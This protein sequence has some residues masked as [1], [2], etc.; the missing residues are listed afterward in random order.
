MNFNEKQQKWKLY[1]PYLYDYILDNNLDWPCTTCQWGPVIQQNSQY[2]KQNIFFACRTDGTYIEQE[3]SWQKQPSQLIV[4]QIDIPQHGKCFNQELRNVYLQ[5]NLKKHTNLKIKQ[6]IIHPGDANIMKKCLLNNKIIATKNDSGF[7]FIWDL[8]KHKNQPQF[9]NTK[10][11]NIPE[12]KLIG[13]STKS[14][15]FALSWA[16]NSYR[17]ASGGKDLAILIWDIENYQTRLSNNYLLNKRELNH[18]GNQNEQFKLKNNITL[19][20]HTEMIEDIS[21]SPNKKDVLVSVGDDKKLL[22]WDLRVSHEK[23]Q[24][25]NDLHNDDINCVDWSIPN[26][27]YIATGS[28]DGT[29]CVMDIRNYKKIV[30]IKTNNEQILNEELSQYSVMSIKFAPF[31]GNYLSIGSDNLYIYDL[32]NLQI[33][34]EQNL[35]KPLLTHFGQKGVINDLDWNTESDWSIMSTCQE[36]DHD[37]SGGGSL[38]IFRPLD[39]IYLPEDEA[40]KNLNIFQMMILLK[41]KKNRIKND[42]LQVIIFLRDL[43]LF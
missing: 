37:N 14:P 29:A 43:S 23:Q 16:K 6:I 7:I 33:D 18:I 11:A 39:L 40:A 10:Y 9:N 41:N 42:V 35:Y 36:F 30:T 5:E 13:H 32:N 24:E 38:Q 31:K 1:N 27:F 19:L 3:N 21:F 15:S 20:G 28:S 34:Y 26:E 4:A 17:I 22:L 2:I 25:V 12:I 8:D